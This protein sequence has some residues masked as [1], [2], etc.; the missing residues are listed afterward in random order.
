MRGGFRASVML[1]GWYTTLGCAMAPLLAALLTASGAAAQPQDPASVNR[2]LAPVEP[3]PVQQLE[4]TE[5]ELSELSQVRT[6]LQRQLDQARTR[7]AEA[8]ARELQ[9]RL[10]QAY[11]ALDAAQVRR[12]ALRRALSPSSAGL[13]T[14]TYTVVS[15]VPQRTQYLVLEHGDGIL[16]QMA[17]MRRTMQRGRLS[18]YRTRDAQ[19]ILCLNGVLDEADRLVRLASKR[20]QVLTR[21]AKT[22]DSHLIG[23]DLTIL[24]MLR[25]SVVK[26]RHQGRRCGDAMVMRPPGRAGVTQRVSPMPSLAD[27][28]MNQ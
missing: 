21:S 28:G 25:D 16:R 23:S 3:T 19:K 10:R 13:P 8:R 15:L 26:V 12:Q 24:A 9:G 18:A 11:G 27:L 5:N 17:A 14:P 6:F 20:R 2:Q 1:M 22:A 7:G 4:Q